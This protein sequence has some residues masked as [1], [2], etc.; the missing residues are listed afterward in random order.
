M[1]TQPNYN[2]MPL[3]EAL[4]V[5]GE[6]T[7]VWWRRRWWDRHRNSVAA[8]LHI[9]ARAIGEDIMVCRALVPEVPSFEEQS[10]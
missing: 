9:L 1:N 3:S 4:E 7:L 8:E 2:W 10:K 6:Y 5:F